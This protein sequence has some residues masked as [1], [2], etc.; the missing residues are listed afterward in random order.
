MAAGEYYVLNDTKTFLD[1]A[2]TDTAD[3]GYLDNMG[4]K[5]NRQIDNDLAHVIDSV[6]VASSSITEELK[7]LATFWVATKYKQK[8]HDIETA[9]SYK[10]DYTAGIKG[11]VNRLIAI[12][13]GRTKRQTSTKDY[14]TEPLQSDPLFDI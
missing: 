10:S 4:L 12:P 8:N 13:T 7:G 2:L 3:D 5:A 11:F 1:I 14:L 6:P 9:N